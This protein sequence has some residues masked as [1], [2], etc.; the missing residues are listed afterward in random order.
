[1]IKS[2]EELLEMTLTD[3]GLTH[4]ME[5]SGGSGKEEACQDQK[6]AQDYFWEIAADFSLFL[7]HQHHAPTGEVA[8]PHPV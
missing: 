6:A 5:R 7:V 4:F 1:V 3:P 8:H 2:R